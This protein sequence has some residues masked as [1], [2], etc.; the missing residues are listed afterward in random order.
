MAIGKDKLQAFVGKGPKG[1]PPGRNVLKAARKGYAEAN[2][3]KAEDMREGGLGQYSQLIPV[4]EEFSKELGK[5]VEES[6]PVALSEEKLPK[7]EAKIIHTE[8]T[9][10]NNKLRRAMY[11]S[12]RDGLSRDQAH[13]L[14]EHLEVEELTED[15]EVVGDWLYHVAKSDILAEVGGSPEEEE[16]EDDG[17]ESDEED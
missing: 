5:A 4:L 17:S 3:V 1:P 9:D 11:D 12:F 16:D 14:A 7:S 6:D 15:P 10:L 8:V 2:G 13:E